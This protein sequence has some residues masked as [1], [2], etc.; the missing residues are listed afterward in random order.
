MQL[1][2]K[3]IDYICQK[4]TQVKNYKKPDCNS[5]IL[6]FG[7]GGFHRAHQAIYTAEAMG[8]TNDYSWGITGVGILESDKYMY[9]CLSDQDFN[10][11]LMVKP[12]EGD[13]NL[14]VVG[15]IS[16]YI[17]AYNNYGKLL[18]KV[19]NPELAIISMTVTEGGYNI[20][21]NTGKFDWSNAEILYDLKQS[22]SPKTIFGYLALCL[23]QRMKMNLRGITLL[24]CDNIQHNGKVLEYTLLEFISR[25]K[26]DLALWVRENC[27]FPSS[28]V[29][30]ITP[31]TTDEDIATIFERFGIEDK[32]PVVCESFTQWIIED[33]FVAGRPKWETA[34]A[35]FTSEVLPYEKMKLRLLNASHQALAYLGHIHGY[36]YVHEA[37]QDKIIQSFL[38]DYM[39]NEV[40]PT[41]DPILGIDLNEYQNNLIERFSN[42]NI[43]D[44]LQRIC[45][46]TSDRI[47]VFN[48][49][50]INEQI[51]QG[52]DLK[53]SAL[54]IASWRAYL[55]EMDE[56]GEKIH[57]VDNRKQMLLEFVRLNPNPIKF[58]EIKDIFH[59]LSSD[60]VFVNNYLKAYLNIKEYGAIAAIS[61]F[62]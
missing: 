36:K 56:K 35:R 27:S 41:L 17:Y 59:E 31:K 29:D 40:E 28:M 6:H 51:N 47:P 37:A 15:T 61:K 42:P 48:L 9:D 2:S 57:I 7:V 5:K 39:K 46:F 60:K 58:I 33:D 62:L 52:K 25:L 50:A 45:E 18:T 21:P 54:I 4:N 43:V 1:N 30:R 44:S 49:P 22:D 10:Y 23:N 26:P 11:S 55:D 38:L 53:L 3:N 13:S 16:D 24:S 12:C 32:W 14:I 34:G 20:D 8:N 19:N